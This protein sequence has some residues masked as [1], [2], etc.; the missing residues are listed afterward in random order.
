MYKKLMCFRK[1]QVIQVFKKSRTRVLLENTA[2]MIFAHMQKSGHI[3]K[4]DILCITVVYV[5]YCLDYFV[6]R[7]IRRGDFSFIPRSC[8]RK[9]NLYF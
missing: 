1:P 6:V 4:G 8:L 5:A 7:L 3:I 9:I 2:K